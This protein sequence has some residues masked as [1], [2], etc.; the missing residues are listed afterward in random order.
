MTPRSGF[1]LTTQVVVGALVVAFG[2]LL[3]ARNIGWLDARDV[4]SL[5]RYWPLAIVFVGISRVV[6]CETSSSRVFGAIVALVGIWLTAELVYGYEL[7]FW[8]LWPVLIVVAGVSMITRAMRRTATG[9]PTPAV[10]EARPVYESPWTSAEFAFW[11]RVERRV[12]TRAFKR[13]DLTSVMG[14]IVYDLRQATTAA[15]DMVIDVFVIWGG[16][17]ILVPPDWVV[18]NHIVP[19][20][21]GVEDGSSG[22]QAAAHRL[23]LRGVVIMGGVEVKT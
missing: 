7:R 19:I 15:G 5:L 2:L 10:A 18:D 4:N 12:T 6:S 23:V 22:T 1:R 3:T 13:A 21:G 20:L 17:E 16:V 9:A 11:S 14:G 8:Q